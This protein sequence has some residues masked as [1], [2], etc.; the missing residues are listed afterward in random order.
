M[1]CITIVGFENQ[2]HLYSGKTC[3]FSASASAKSNSCHVCTW[4]VT[5]TRTVTSQRGSRGSN[6]R[7][8]QGSS[9]D[10]R[11]S[12]SPPQ[13]SKYAAEFSLECFFVN[14][15]VKVTRVIC[16]SYIMT[17]SIASQLGSRG[18]NEKKVNENS[19]IVSKDSTNA[20]T[21]T[22]GISKSPPQTPRSVDMKS[23][24]SGVGDIDLEAVA[25]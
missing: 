9:S 18:S 15:S 6:A 21:P 3:D 8:S 19:D 20:A 13:T 1:E 25:V 11:K 14:S 4:Y 7:K 22:T 23:I 10:S 16:T 2:K 12:K 17:R 24:E 5:G